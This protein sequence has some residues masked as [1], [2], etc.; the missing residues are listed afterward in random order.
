[1]RKKIAAVMAL[2]LML[3][4]AAGC[5]QK[6]E[7]APQ[8]SYEGFEASNRLTGG[9]EVAEANVKSL[10][11][12]LDGDD[13]CLTFGFLSGSRL[14]GGESESA[15]SGAPAYAVYMLKNP[16][17]LIVEFT[18]ISYWDYTRELAGADAAPLFGFFQTRFKGD[19]LLRFTFQLSSDAVYKAEE[20]TGGLAVTLRP[21]AK[22]ALTDSG[23]ALDITQGQR[24]YAV[25]DA[26]RDYCD[27]TLPRDAGVYPAL[28]RNGSDILMLSGA[29]YS[30]AEAKNFLSSLAAKNEGVVEEQWSVAP[31]KENEAPQI[32]ER[33]AHD[34]AYAQNVLR[35]G[36]VENEAEVFIEDGLYLCHTPDKKGVLYSRRMEGGQPGVDEYAYEMIYYREGNAAA[37][38]YLE[39]EFQV[40]EQVKF[41]PDGR[42]L[43]VLERDEE[44]THLYVFDAD[45]RELLTDLTEVGFGELV[46]AFTWDSLGL[47]IYAVSGSG[48]MQVHAYDFGVPQEGKRHSVV[49]KN[50]ADEGYLAY[51]DGELYFI[52][53][54]MNTGEQ[55]YRIKPD[56]GVRKAFTAGG[57]FAFSPDNRYMALGVSGTGVETPGAAAGF[58]LYDMETG[59]TEV[60]TTEFSVS[61]FLW[62]LSGARLYYVENRL[63]G[64]GGEEATSGEDEPEASAVP[65]AGDPYPYT[66][67]VY[68][69]ASKQAH[70]LMDLPSPWIVASL[71][72]DELYLN[73]YDAQTGG[74]L[75]RA[76]YRLPAA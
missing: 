66:L 44:R 41:S 14:S 2:F 39:R 53:S 68:D 43:A 28:A 71:G 50:G 35:V 34:R 6:A 25:A 19:T 52:Q 8:I 30:E 23:S 15:V 36:G 1:M 18:N 76:T 33:Q 55:I 58:S 21:I 70:A 17:R 9:V 31:L 46:S 16:A 27:G 73:Y 5:A 56:G 72:A 75:V 7:E 69:A 11:F 62:S 54:D 29:F 60:I 61:N 45:A 12:A 22:P 13:L 40:V 37:R 38:P 3:A 10:G 32:D 67:W 42:K 65:A 57:A 47:S 49:D 48:A 59:K 4:L 64:V 63:A 20:V 51:C 24:Y 26:Y 74:D